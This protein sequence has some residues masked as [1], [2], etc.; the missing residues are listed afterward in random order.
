[1]TAGCGRLPEPTELVAQLE[2]AG[3]SGVTARSLIPGESF[4]AFVGTNHAG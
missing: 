2:A 3:F 1:M 4:Y